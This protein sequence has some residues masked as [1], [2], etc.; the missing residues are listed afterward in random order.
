MVLTDWLAISL[1][2][3]VGIPMVLMIGLKG[4]P[5]LW[6]LCSPCNLGG[7]GPC[8]RRSHSETHA[9]REGPLIRYF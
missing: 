7:L 4:T 9:G 8:S 1:L 6:I 2:L 3:Y 5:D